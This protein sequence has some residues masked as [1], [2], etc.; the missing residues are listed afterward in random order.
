VYDLGGATFGGAI[1]DP[2]SGLVRST[3]LLDVGGTDFD[4][5]LLRTLFPADPGQGETC[6]DIKHVLSLLDAVEVAGDGP[7]GSGE[8]SRAEFEGGIAPL[9]ERTLTECDRL[10]EDCGLA[11]ADLTAVV[12][13]G[14]SAR[15][16]LVQRRLEERAPGRV[17]LAPRPESAVA[18]GAAGGRGLPAASAA[19]APAPERPSRPVG[20][21]GGPVVRL[22][23]GTPRRRGLSGLVSRLLPARPEPDGGE[24][25]RSGWFGADAGPPGFLLWYVGRPGVRVFELHRDPV[26]RY[27]V[28]NGARIALLHLGPQ[29]AGPAVQTATLRWQRRLHALA[30]ARGLPAVSLTG[31]T[32]VPGQTPVPAGGP[33]TVTEAGLPDV[34]ARVVGVGAG[35]VL[36]PVCALLLS[37]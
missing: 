31:L 27:A 6:R 29:G 4:R 9:V 1:V 22:L 13:I 12:L 28:V 17:V 7:P 26:F 23:H 20:R 10:R 33:G 3:E 35:E 16:P 2:V 32:V 25:R 18:L 34:L 14:G 19:A 36:V 8:V 15:V 11:W 30:V 24:L 37:A 21:P 5:V